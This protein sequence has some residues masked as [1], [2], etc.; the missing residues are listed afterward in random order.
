MGEG[1]RDAR[2]YRYKNVQSRRPTVIFDEGTVT[3]HYVDR[4]EAELERVKSQAAYAL[5]EESGV[6]ITPEI[7]RHDQSSTTWRRLPNLRPLA[8]ELKADANTAITHQAGAVLAHIHDNLHIPPES[9]SDAA[10]PL[11]GQL[12]T[13]HGDFSLDNVQIEISN[14]RLVVLDW[15]TAPWL[16][17]FTRASQHTDMCIFFLGLFRRRPAEQPT[18]DHPEAL[19]RAFLAG[20]G[21][22]RDAH[23]E[24]L[25]PVLLYMLRRFIAGGD[26][27]W[28]Q[29]LR[30]SSF[31][32]LTVETMKL[33][34]ERRDLSEWPESA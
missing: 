10:A 4:S 33:A 16:G 22:V 6:F 5:A 25:R 26:V 18:I 13:T 29:T 24:D 12:V 30:M 2:R 19:A 15:S 21:E 28:R 34:G 3:K 11:A 8:A 20:Y 23:A 31:A 14:R 7:V 32:A 1:R 9:S 17:S 27:W